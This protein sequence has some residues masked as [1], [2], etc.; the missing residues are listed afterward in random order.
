MPCKE[1]S[2]TYQTY[3]RG[4]LKL[5]I[6]WALTKSIPSWM[7][8]CSSTTAMSRYSHFLRKLLRCLAWHKRRLK[9]P[10]SKI[11][12]KAILVFLCTRELNRLTAY[13]CRLLFSVMRF[14]TSQSMMTNLQLISVSSSSRQK[15]P[16]LW[17]N[18]SLWVALPLTPL[19]MFTVNNNIS[20]KDK[21]H[22][23]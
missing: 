8:L 21:F 6:S 16:N 15:M 19:W 13:Q 18:P 4:L 5:T 2:M 22:K 12:L 7:R 3:S 23:K 10:L 14:I 11:M 20:L 1:L 17:L 9:F